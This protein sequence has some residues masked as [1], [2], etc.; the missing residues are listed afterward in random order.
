MADAKKD[1]IVQG[2]VQR[3]ESQRE[4]VAKKIRESESARVAELKS[5]QESNKA[6]MA[7]D[8]ARLADEDKKAKDLKPSNPQLQPEV[9]PRLTGKLTEPLGKAVR[10]VG[11]TA[12][13][14]L[15]WTCVSK[16]TARDILQRAYGL[17][18]QIG[19]VCTPHDGDNTLTFPNG[20]IIEFTWPDKP[21]PKVLPKAQPSTEAQATNTT[22]APKP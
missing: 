16:P 9:Y 12:R 22:E 1:P 3:E 19:L 21:L 18:L 6:R 4:K 10:H 13:F 20:S 2:H 17:A 15:A 5:A 14:R 8:A 11:N 7:A